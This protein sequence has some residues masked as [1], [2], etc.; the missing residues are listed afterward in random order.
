MSRNINIKP[1]NMAELGECWFGEPYY[2]DFK[3]CDMKEILWDNMGEHNPLLVPS[4]LTAEEGMYR[5]MRYMD[6]E[7]ERR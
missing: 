3:G 5:L 6:R 7:G 2:D 1:M 4:H